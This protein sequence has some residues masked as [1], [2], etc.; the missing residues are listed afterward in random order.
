[1][2]TILPVLQKLRGML[3]SQCGQFFQ[4]IG[5]DCDDILVIRLIV[6][7]PHPGKQVDLLHR[8]PPQEAY[9]PFYLFS[10]ATATSRATFIMVV[11]EFCRSSALVSTPF[12]TWSE[13]VQ[14]H[15]P[16]LP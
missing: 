10:I 13:M 14:M 3:S 7:A 1:M 9:L 6:A 11:K 16:R 5:A 12:R 2:P 4:R 8:K 15:R